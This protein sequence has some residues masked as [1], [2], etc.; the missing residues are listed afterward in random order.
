[1]RNSNINNFLAL[2]LRVTDSTNAMLAYWDKD[3]ICRFANKAYLEWFGVEP[4]KMINKMHIRDLL[5]PT[6]YKKNLPYIEQV[7][8]GHAQLFEREI[9]TPSGELRNSI[10]NYYPDIANET[11]KG[12]F[13]HVADVT[14][15]RQ[16]NLAAKEGSFEHEDK[17][18]EVERKLRAI[19]PGKF[20]GLTVLAHEHYI[21]VSK[22]K[23]DFKKKYNATIG[24][25]FRFLQMQYA[26]Q[27]LRDKHFNKKQIADLL[28]FSNHSNFSAS[29]QKYLQQKKEQ[30]IKDAIKQVS[31]ENY[32]AFIT[33]APCALAMFDNNLNFLAASYLWIHIN[34]LENTS[35]DERNIY[36]IFPHI[37][38]R[39]KRIYDHC[40]KGNIHAGEGLFYTHTQTPRYLKWDIRPWYDNKVIGGVLIFIED[41]S[42]LKKIE[43]ENIR[44]NKI[45][46]KASELGQIGTWERD[47]ITN[48]ATWNKITLD[49]LELPPDYDPNSLPSTNFYKEGYSRNMFQK[50][51]KLAMQKGKTFDFEAEVVTAKGNI[52]KVRVIGYP[53]M[54]D[55]TCIKIC[56]II[57]ALPQ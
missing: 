35:L 7:L 39:W 42:G 53:E 27:Y 21:S 46:S 38:K 22:L 31:Y 49:I 33:Q 25:Y 40:L 29:Y 41:I 9:T 12:F 17:I 30:T 50:S 20:P 10:A 13:V 48:I 24:E 19:L 14:P 56:G 55:N 26:E 32:K 5:G 47:V 52:K 18:T 3:L 36:D 8:K 4:E 51:F 57:Q 44:T 11:V 34:S 1:M 16:N 6:L 28:G 15:I 54:K 23:R 45:L 2:G 43:S 37:H